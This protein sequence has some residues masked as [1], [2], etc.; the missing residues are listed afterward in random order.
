VKRKTLPLICILSFFTVIG[1]VNYVIDPY[2]LYNQTSLK[3][4]AIELSNGANITNVNNI[5]ERSLQKYIIQNKAKG[6]DIV[7]MGSSRVMQL[8]ED[9]FVPKS[10]FNSGLSAA[11]I[12]DYMLVYGYYSERG[13]LPNKIILAVD[14]WVFNRNHGF[15]RWFPLAKDV[16]KFEKK[17]FRSNAINWHSRHTLLNSLRL[18]LD[19]FMPDMFQR[20]ILEFGSSDNKIIS[21]TERRTNKRTKLSDGSRSYEY[22]RH[23]R[24]ASE[25]DEI[26]K[27]HIVEEVPFGLSEFELDST[28]IKVFGLF[29]DKCIQDNIDIHLVLV[30]YHPDYYKFLS[31]DNKYKSITKVEDIVVQIAADLKI[32]IIGS[33]SPLKVGLDKE[34]FYDPYHPSEKGMQKLLKGRLM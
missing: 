30:P 12:E 10:F 3:I 9:F 27:K 8:R 5:D 26:V 18:Y 19:L 29:I 32:G 6:H 23:N 15:K 7:A 4:A 2:N 24:S 28:L 21:T 1:L 16:E 20:S 25:I 17:Y 33:Y 11:T 14:P 22:Q 13:I 34:D 31:Q